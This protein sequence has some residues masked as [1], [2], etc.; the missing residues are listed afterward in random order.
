[1]IIEISILFAFCAMLCWAFGDFFI[2]RSIRKVGDIEVLAIIGI[3][4]T[5]GLLPFVFPDLKLLLSFQ[6]IILV[7]ILGIIT[8]IMS[9]VDFEALKEGKLSIIEVILEL[10]LPIAV[11]LSF[12][13]LKESISMRQLVI[14][15][16][17]LLGLILIATKSFSHWRTKLERGVIL[18]FFAAILM[19]LTDFLTAK[20]SRSISPL[21]AV[22]VPWLIFTIFS[23]VVIAKRRDLKKFGANLLQFKWLLLVTGIIDTISWI[24]YSYATHNYNVAIVTAI[25][26]CYPAIAMFLGLWLNKEHIKWYQYVGAILALAGSIILALIVG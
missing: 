17:M 19:G 18:A 25:T 16:V 1:M 22:W 5:V 2:Q 11:V 8:C 12:I 23:L 15:I 4:G 14:I 26:E 6:N 9:V 13:F 3:V 10:E 21:L 7:S 24:F 20:S